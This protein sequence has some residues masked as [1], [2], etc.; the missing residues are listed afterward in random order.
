VHVC[1]CV[2][3]EARGQCKQSS[4]IAFHLVFFLINYLFIICEYTVSSDT[5][6][7]GVRSHYRWF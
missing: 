2:H 5:Q 7:E 6:E 4:S 3:V 1:A